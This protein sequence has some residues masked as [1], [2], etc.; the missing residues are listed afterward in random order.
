MR[1]PF[2][3]EG[4]ACLSI[5]G[6]RT[7]GYML[8]RT[9][10]ANG[11]ELPPGVVACFANTGKE[12]EATLR[13][14]RNMEVQWGVKIHWL[15]FKPA[16]EPADRWHEVTFDTASREG[17]PFEALIQ[18]KQY[19]PN[20]VTR[21]CTIEL[22]IRP[23]ARFLR[24]HGFDGT[25]DDLE[26]ASLVGIRADEPRRVVK[27]KDRTRM[28]LV[29]AGVDAAAVGAFWKAHPFDLEL[30][31]IGGRTMHGNCD[32]C[33][34]KPAAQVFSLIVEKP[35]RA[36]W[37][38]KMEAMA[39]ASKPSGAVFRSDRPG[40]AQML[41]FAGEQGDMFDHEEEAIACFCGD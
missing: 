36:V 38:A 35:A 11:G 2:E 34:L 19:L 9:L 13:F 16:E 14:V 37:W 7:S 41:K 22:K 5:S 30:P 12:E 10:E 40:Y 3:I 20:P 21:F 15:E 31:N 1:D 29:S 17:E 25:M 18:Q 33:F 28:P 27:I 24:H 32:L 39:M 8:W 4:Q 23:I 6:G 26:N